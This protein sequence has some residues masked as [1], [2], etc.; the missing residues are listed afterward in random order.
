[1]NSLRQSAGILVAASFFSS[2][3]YP[4]PPSGE[5]SDLWYIPAESG[6]GMQ[7]VQRGEVIFA[8]LFVYGPNGT[9]TWFSAT[10]NPTATPYQSSGDLYATTGPWFGTVPFN[11]ATV[12][13]T[14][15][16]TM[17]W[18]GSLLYKG[19]LTYTVN[20]VM[21][22]KNP[23][24]QTLVNENYGGALLGHVH[25]VV[26]QCSNAAQDGISEF[27]T[28][29]QITQANGSTVVSITGTLQP[30]N[31]CNYIGT[32]TQYGQ[33]GS[34]TG[35][36]S[37]SNGDGGAFAIDALQQTPFGMTGAFTQTSSTLGC[38]HTGWFGA[39]YSNPSQ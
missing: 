22:V 26:A 5:Q 25:D 13:E 32:L 30:G 11:P 2:P 39:M 31:T 8:T 34:I 37:C 14:K 1:M 4:I 10:M 35:S 28:G 15:V 29:L 38:Q 21:V 9:P 16:G 36:Y 24:R 27:V 3:A 6:W 20:G 19:V 33:M 18:D 17:T 7:L 12:V 23:V